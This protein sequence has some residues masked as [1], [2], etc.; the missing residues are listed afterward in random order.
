VRTGKTKLVA[1]GTAAALMVLAGCKGNSPTGGGS[2]TAGS[3]PGL[4]K[5]SINIGTIADL[6]GPVPGLFQGAV[7]G[8]Q[9]YVAYANSLG[10]INGR[11]LVD[12][13]KDSAL[14]C[15]QDSA[16]AA[17]LASSTFA[18]VGSFALYDTCTIPTL[19][20]NPTVPYVAVALSTPLGALPNSFNPQPILDGFRT[21]P[22]KYL[23]QKYGVSR[24]GFLGAS[25]A[26][27]PV[28]KD[29]LAAAV[30]VGA[31]A[32]YTRFVGTTETDFTADVIRM[33]KAKVDWINASTL[34]AADIAHLLVNMN[35]QNF[36]PKVIQAAPAYDAKLFGLLPNPSLANGVLMDQ[37]YA[38]FQ[39]EDNATVPGVKTFTTWMTKEFPKFKPDLFT[40]YGWASAALFAQAL[41][42]AGP[43][44]TR[45]SVLA[46]LKSI[47][48]FTAD[49][50]LAPSN[51]GQKKP[52]TCW[53]L[54]KIEN[55]K[56]SRITPNTG[57]QC[58][59]GGFYYAKS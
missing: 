43:S 7:D 18:M 55:S 48:S 30:S 39:G 52:S 58:T 49:G 12:V 44:P 24:I 54:I 19:T 3:E 26:T 1:V 6:T 59:P 35:Q 29:Q 51:P 38:M 46:Q 57:Y 15:A 21:G 25:G 56:Y 27:E 28:E 20:K 2:G 45:T 37:T 41:K 14:S 34:D 10:G 11:K 40:M 47:H 8:V 13:T 53:I 32:A 4:T 16:G 36:H 42:A 5:T 33:R 31:K 22:D 23:M 50:L 9:A 17:S